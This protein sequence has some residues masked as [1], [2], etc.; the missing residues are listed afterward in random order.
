MRAAAVLRMAQQSSS[1]S[2]H[3]PP[4]QRLS[5]PPASAVLVWD[6]DE[7]VQETLLEKVQGQRPSSSSRKS[8]NSSKK[9]I[10]APATPAKETSSSTIADYSSTP[11]KI[12]SAVTS[13]VQIMASMAQTVIDQFVTGG[14]DPSGYDFDHNPNRKND[15]P[16]Y[17]DDFAAG[18]A[19]ASIT[20]A[21]AAMSLTQQQQPASSSHSAARRARGLHGPRSGM[22]RLPA[23]R[24]DG[25]P[26]TT[27][28][29]S[30]GGTFAAALVGGTATTA[31]CGWW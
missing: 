17:A 27:R 11:R 23:K 9:E 26:A 4:Q 7:R 6:S 2:T 15:T 1:T 25:A 19:M 10:A 30:R 12:L 14:D 8:N 5:L 13:P 18:A 16:D 20:T 28:T 29:T 24:P 21:T 3:A 22:P 31:A